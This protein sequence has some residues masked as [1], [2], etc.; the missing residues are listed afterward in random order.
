M[1]LKKFSPRKFFLICFNGKITT[2][3][4]FRASGV[5]V[6]S[7]MRRGRSSLK[8][9]DWFVLFDTSAGSF[10]GHGRVIT[11]PSNIFRCDGDFF[12]CHF[13]GDVSRRRNKP[14]DLEQEAPPFLK[15]P[16][17]KRLQGWQY[18][19]VSRLTR[20][21]FDAIFLR[22]WGIYRFSFT[23]PTPRD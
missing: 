2:V 13:S 22:W 18:R 10:K 4:D 20:A 19:L 7:G 9:D 3:D 1:P 5:V 15:N 11:H 21:E 8:S 23:L 12:E 17:T 6:A 14:L 16:T